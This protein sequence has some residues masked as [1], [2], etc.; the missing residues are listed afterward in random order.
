MACESEG[1]RRVLK[2][3]RL[4]RDKDAQVD[5]T[6]HTMVAL[7]VS[8]AWSPAVRWLAFHARLPGIGIGQIP[9]MF[10]RFVRRRV[11]FELDPDDI[12]LIR[13]PSAFASDIRQRL[14]VSGDCDDMALLLSAMLGSQGFA[15]EFVVMAVSPH[16]SEFRHIFTR[17]FMG[18]EKWLGL[19]PS[20][21]R[22]YD[23][24]GLRTKRYPV[25]WRRLPPIIR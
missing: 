21:E 1:R 11:A 13:L 19:D 2:V 5:I 14:P 23:T 22:S 15:T 7:A 20:V 18:G 3:T 12:E 6:A 4:P 25:P 10:S 16:N 17:V 24:K 9:G 8:Q